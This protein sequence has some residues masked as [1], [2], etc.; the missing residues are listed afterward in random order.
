MTSTAFSVRRG[1]RWAVAASVVALAATGCSTNAASSTSGAGYRS[2]DA[3]YSG[4]ARPAAG[5]SGVRAIL[6]PP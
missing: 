1:S 2:G 4:S 5:A 3:D 6:R